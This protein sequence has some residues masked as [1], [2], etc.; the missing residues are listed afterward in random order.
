MDYADIQVTPGVP[1]T[2]LQ[3][4]VH[5]DQKRHATTV[6]GE[7]H[8][9]YVVMP[10]IERLLEDLWLNGGETPGDRERAARIE[11]RRI[12]MERGLVKMEPSSP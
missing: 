12:K 4:L 9:G 7:V 10:D 8:K 1:N 5:L 3:Q 2:F 11:E 6:L